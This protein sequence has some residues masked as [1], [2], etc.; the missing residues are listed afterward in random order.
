MSTAVPSITFSDTGIVLPLESAILSG[1]QSDF[2]TA[3]GQT[4]NANPDTPQ[5]QLEAS[6]SAII[7]NNNDY[8]AWLV[9]QVNPDYSDGFMQ[10]AIARIY[11]IDRIPATGTAVTCQCVGA[12]GTVIPLGN[13]VVDTSGN[14]YVSLEE[15]TIPEAGTVDVSFQNV[16]TG[17][18]PCA[19]GS[20]T[21]IYQTVP[22]WDSVSNASAGVTGRAVESRADFEYR[23]SESVAVNGNGSLPSIKANV[24]KVAG[25]LDCYAY[26]NWTGSAIEVG[27]TNYSLL[28]HSIYIAVEGGDSEAIAQAI[29]KYNNPGADMNGNVSVPVYDTSYDYPYPEY[30]ITFQRPEELPIL[31][32]A[33]LVNNPNLPHD[34]EAQTKAAIIAAFTGADGGSR[35]RIGAEIVAGRFYGGLSAISPYVSILS[36]LLGTTTA[37][38]T[39]VTPGIDQYPIISEDNITITLI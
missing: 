9:N 17:A 26:Q 29:F 2:N 34:I 32:E 16:V 39:R 7:A 21:T 14:I 11:F 37:T 31:I 6:L 18:I 38:D 3:F 25:V 22:G 30:T 20:I 24:M 4:L 33:R 12:A 23:R 10:D 28:P 8:W 27:T 15:A 1:V 36:V 35:A 5:G 19:A 13:K